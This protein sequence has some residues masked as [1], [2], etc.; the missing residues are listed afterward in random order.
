LHTL[1]NTLAM[2]IINK[3][4]KGH[5]VAFAPPGCVV[6][7]WICIRAHFHMDV[8]LEKDLTMTCTHNTQVHRN[9]SR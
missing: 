9:I 8:H 7:V 1:V 5:S 6:S 2:L 4:Q 3:M